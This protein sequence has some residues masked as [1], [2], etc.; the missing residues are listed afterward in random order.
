M[1][2][3]CL[4]LPRKA[5]HAF[6]M[7]LAAV[8]FS[9]PLM[10]AGLLAAAVPVVLHLLNR[11]RAPVVPFPTLRFL[12][13]TAE[14]TVRR[15]QIQQYFLLLVRIVVFALMAMAVASPLI[16]G[17]SASLAYSMVGMVL[18]GLALLVLA[19][20]LGA[21]AVN[22]RR[23]AASI[24]APPPKATQNSPN[25]ALR[26]FASGVVMVAALSLLG[27]GAY[28]LTSDRYFSSE[29]G[30]FS[31]RSTALVIIFDNSHSMLAMEAGQTRLMRAKSQVRQLLGQAIQPAEAAILPTNPADQPAPGLTSDMAR[32]VG[33]LD[34]LT[35]RG[36]ARPLQERIRT[37]LDLLRSS[38]QPGKMLVIAS[39]FA[40][41]AIADAEL[42]MPLKTLPWRRDLQLILMP[43]RG[44]GKEH[45]FPGVTD[46]PG[47]ADVGI[48]SFAPAAGTQ[49]PALGAEMTL[50]A[51]VINNQNE[52]DVRDFVL[53]MDGKPIDGSAS[54]TPRVTLSGAGNGGAGRAVVKLPYRPAE[55]GMHILGLQTRGQNDAMAWDD[56]REF[57]VDVADQIRVLVIGRDPPDA[58]GMPPTRSAAFFAMAALAPY[59]TAG[60]R[61]IPWAVKPTYRATDQAGTALDLQE[62]SAVFLCDVPQVS[63]SLAAALTAYARG[64]PG[65]RGG[66][67]VWMLGPNVNAQAYNAVLLGAG[68]NLLP[69]PLA[70]PVITPKAMPLNWVDMHAGI[71]SDLFESQDPFR[72][73]LVTGRWSFISPADGADIRGSVIGKLSDDSPLMMQH[74][75]SGSPGSGRIF[76][77]LTSPASAWSNLGG[78]VLFVPLVSRMALGDFRESTPGSYQE[79]ETVTFSLPET[80]AA[81]RPAVD[82][83]MPDGAVLN[84]KPTGSRPRWQFDRTFA[85]GTYRWKTTDGKAEGAFVVNPPGDEADLSPGDI[86]ALA[87]ESNSGSQ[88]AE[89]PAIVAYSVPELLGQME[90]R[91]EGTS[92]EPGFIAM[93]LMLAVVEA[94]MANRVK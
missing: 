79:G 45:D 84:I 73:L 23:K 89:R 76:T 35:P 28:G 49:R 38:Q 9:D 36:E 62:Y 31:G 39:D 40:Q 58:R 19:G 5:G 52:P 18:G 20:V 83:T 81:A 47:V 90:H 29:R 17:G 43:I 94:M 85:D 65:R 92:L 63:E 67:I 55:P 91:S 6:G 77:L 46:I 12:K 32:L 88:A 4:A 71:F 75:L 44:S 56:T 22:P 33:F 87:R 70:Q 8:S 93:V 16:R 25:Y 21:A 10:L 57:A 13:L 64:N 26:W 72:T 59:E 37:A 74:D 54:Q 42:L 50:E 48:L 66:R 80:V 34:R 60:P 53:T 1:P 7:V 3:I 68:R 14:K 86:E 2:Q 61:A 30:D 51:Q 27:F 15:R 41:P 82:V 78:T 24:D 69:A 11:L